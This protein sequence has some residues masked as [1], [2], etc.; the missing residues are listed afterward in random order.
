MDDK[1]IFASGLGIDKPWHIERIELVGE[2]LRKELHIYLN[3]EKGCHFTYEGK[4]HSVY[5][6]QER[7]WHHLRFFQHECFLHAR[8]PR[9]KTDEGKVKLIEVPWAQPG[10]SFTLLFELR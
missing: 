10:S 6:H 9:I 2:E 8:V 7:V 1:E 4:K 5:D 3:H